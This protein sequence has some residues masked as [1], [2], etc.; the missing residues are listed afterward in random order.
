MVRSSH[1]SHS[2]SRDTAAAVLAPAACPKDEKSS[3]ASSSSSVSMVRKFL[4]TSN[5]IHT[6]M[7]EP[8][9]NALRHLAHVYSY[10]VGHGKTEQ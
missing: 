8:N 9:S 2:S 5:F 3:S 4:P 1:R 10:F 7:C 6:V